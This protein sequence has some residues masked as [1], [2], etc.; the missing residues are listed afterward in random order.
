[1]YQNPTK[2]I[3]IGYCEE[4]RE[5]ASQ[6]RDT[7]LDLLGNDVWMRDF[8]LDGGSLLV[9]SLTDAAAKAKWFLLFISESSLNCQWLKTE[10]NLMT[11]RAIEPPRVSRRPF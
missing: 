1:M 9:E 3:F 10:A 7:L 8:D 6:L 4:D 2:N 11:F 5:L